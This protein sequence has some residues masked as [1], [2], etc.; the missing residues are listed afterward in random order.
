MKYSSNMGKSDKFDFTIQFGSL[1]V[2]IVD[3]QRQ[4]PA[5]TK[6]K[7]SDRFESKI[8]KVPVTRSS[9]K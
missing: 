7:K 1:K 2:Y 6:K 4:Q 5:S 8:Y 9:W 3:T